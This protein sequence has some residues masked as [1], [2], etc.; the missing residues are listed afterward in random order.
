MI[1]Q[2]QFY[3]LQDHVDE[4]RLEKMIRTTRSILLKIPEVLSVRSGRSIEPDA[5]WPFFVSLEYETLDKRNISEDDPV[6]LKFHEQV[7]KP[8]TTAHYIMD[9]ELDPSK[10]LKYS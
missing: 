9:Y 2:I 7:T 6:Y 3:K 10:D 4:A 1:Q 5:D 8:N